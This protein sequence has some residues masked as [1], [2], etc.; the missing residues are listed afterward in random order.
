MPHL[1]LHEV[2]SRRRVVT[3]TI[4]AALHDTGVAAIRFPSRL[5]GLP[6][7]ALFEGRCRLSLVA[8]PLPLTDPP[9]DPLTA[10]AAEW[11]LTVEPAPARADLEPLVRR[12]DQADDRRGTVVTRFR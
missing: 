2:T 12:R 7:L 3:Q 8:A 1:D 11:R 4:A 9:P 10:V 5:D 6:C